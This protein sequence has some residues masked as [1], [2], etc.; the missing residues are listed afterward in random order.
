MIRKELSFSIDTKFAGET[1]DQ[2]EDPLK[3]S[4]TVGETVEDDGF[5]FGS[6]AMSMIEEDCDENDGAEGGFGPSD[7]GVVD[8]WD[9]SDPL[10]LRNYAQFL[11]VGNVILS[12]NSAVRS[13]GEFFKAE[14][15]YDR[16][17]MADPNNGQLMCNY[18][19]LVWELYHDK[20]QAL[21]YFE[22]AVHAAP[23]DSDILGAYSN[24]LWEIDEE[25]EGHS[26]DTQADDQN[27]VLWND[28]TKDFEEKKRPISPPLHLAM[29]LGLNMPSTRLVAD[30]KTESTETTGVEEYYRSML[31]KNSCD[32]LFLKD[33]TEFLNLSKE[34]LLGAEEYY[35]RAILD[36]STNGQII[37][38]YANLVWQLYQDKE[39]AVAYFNQAIE[40]TP[41]DSAVLASYAKFLWEI[42]DDEEDSAESQGDEQ[43][44]LS[45]ILEN[46][47]N[48]QI[49]SEYASLVWRLHGDKKRA[50][51]YFKQAIQANPED[52]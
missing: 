9:P 36:D 12:L 21:A 7:Y 24:F 48:G 38:Q 39:R 42:E 45:A 16:A 31:E 3:K 2:K 44:Y 1:T 27:G 11:Q 20:E 14:E 8:G 10:S 37:S 4:V 34:D 47:R 40:A 35:S 26:S 25:E 17:M 23:E 15:Y 5:S 52:R 50:N 51:T 43:R 22:R 19:K 33:R 6:H 32:P 28:M 49:M 29:G 41:T 30:M 46:P 18:A 13:R